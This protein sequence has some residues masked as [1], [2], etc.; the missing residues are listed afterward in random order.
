MPGRLVYFAAVLLRAYGSALPVAEKPGLAPTDE[1]AQSLVN[2]RWDWTRALRSPVFIQSETLSQVFTRGEAGYYCNK[3]P[4]VLS[5]ASGT[6]LAFGE[7][8]MLSC[9]DFTWTDIVLKRSM[10][11]G[12]TWSPLQVVYSNSSNR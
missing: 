9:S 10:D 6:I 12:E 7:G 1:L 2:I 11:G 4:S 5:L 8:R 3:I